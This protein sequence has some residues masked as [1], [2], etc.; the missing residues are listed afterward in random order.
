M[1]AWTSSGAINGY[2]AHG[3]SPCT[4]NP[5]EQLAACLASEHHYCAHGIDART[6][7]KEGSHKCPYCRGVTRRERNPDTW[8]PRRPDIAL[9]AT[10]LEDR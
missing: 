3:Q 6:S 4:G 9:P 7:T 10:D 2:C 1:S 8:R 5:S